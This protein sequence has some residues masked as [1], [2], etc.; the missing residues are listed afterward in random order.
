M[1]SEVLLYFI[2]D[3]GDFDSLHW[4]RPICSG[5]LWC[6][7]HCW[8]RNLPVIAMEYLQISTRSY[9]WEGRTW[10][11]SCGQQWYKAGFCYFSTLRTSTEYDI[12]RNIQSFSSCSNKEHD[13][14]IRVRPNPGSK[15]AGSLLRKLLKNTWNKS[16]ECKCPTHGG[17]HWGLS[18][19]S[20]TLGW[21]AHSS[22]H[23]RQFNW[24]STD[25]ENCKSSVNLHL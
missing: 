14:G 19:K 12:N 25:I 6:L 3:G 24:Q 9:S 11:K 15:R 4:V 16:K 1:V 17:K 18:A 21:C 22:S 20:K 10:G 7:I 2:P 8:K 13:I 23:I 5:F